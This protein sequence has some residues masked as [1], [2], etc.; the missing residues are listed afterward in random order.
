MAAHYGPSARAG[1]RYHRVLDAIFRL[2]RAHEDGVGN[3]RKLGVDALEITQQV[4]VERA[5]LDALTLSQMQALD[6]GLHEILR[7]LGDLHLVAQ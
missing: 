1:R 3:V 6:A 7:H 2:T 5:R 4:Q